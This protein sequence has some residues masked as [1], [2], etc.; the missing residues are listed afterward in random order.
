MR[1]L[2]IACMILSVLIVAPVEAV[3]EI[4][5]KGVSKHTLNEAYVVFQNVGSAPLD[6]TGWTILDEA[7]HSYL[8][9]R[10]ILHPGQT[11]TLYTGLGK[12]TPSALYWGSGRSIWN[13]AGDTII[14]KDA[15]GNLVLSHIY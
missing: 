5:V 15:E 14:V 6:M 4:S 10:F 7:N 3:K 12:N 8:V 9:P 1:S 13:K 11:F 2:C